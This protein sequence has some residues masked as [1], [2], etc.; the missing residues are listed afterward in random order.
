[1]AILWGSYRSGQTGLTVNQLDYSFGG[2]NPPLP[3]GDLWMVRP[4]RASNGH[5]RCARC[6]A[7]PSAKRV[8]RPCGRSLASSRGH[9]RPQERRHSRPSSSG[10]EHNLGKVGVTGSIP[11]SGSSGPSAVLPPPRPA[12]CAR[13]TWRR[14]ERAAGP[15]LCV[16]ART[17]PVQVS[18]VN[19]ED[20][21]SQ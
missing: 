2:S 10:V 21:G 5:Q 16:W 17:S 13:E 6:V 11:V 9:C 14:G 20:A 18:S 12:P 15:L 1:M 3:T 8:S 4:D 19:Q 7:Q